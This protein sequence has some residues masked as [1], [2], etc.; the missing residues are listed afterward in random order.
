ML[1]SVRALIIAGLSAL[2]LTP[3]GGGQV[4]SA[5]S[6]PA[7]D[8]QPLSVMTY[9]IKGLP[10][11]LASGREAALERIADRLA[12]LRRERRQPHIVL[13]QEAFVPQA[14]AIAA[15]AGYPYSVAG[16]H[17]ALR[18]PVTPERDDIAYLNGAFWYYGEQVG[19]SL[20]SGLLILSDYPITGS[21]RLAFPD[22][23]CAGFDCLANKG[24]LLAELRVPGIGAV[25]VVDT[26]LN[27]RRAAGV[28]VA[29]SQRAFERQAELLADFVRAQVPAGRP[30]VLGGDMNIG[31]DPERRR[32]FFGHF[33]RVGLGFVA[34]P[35]GGL[36]RALRQ[37]A[38]IDAPTRSDLAQAD[39]H[40]KD[41]LFARGTG[42]APLPVASGRVPFG[43]EPRGEPL[44]DHYGYQIGYAIRRAPT[45]APT[46]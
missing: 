30:L 41:W 15:R 25:S 24:A 20:G 37:Q 18:I 34:P 27:A 9:N 14:A 8:D 33:A 32:A 4:R 42:N 22:F 31:G 5:A 21:A 43:A 12:L 44:S 26:H 39:R 16:P 3:A 13:M 38:R 36:K 6:A 45:R 35:L 40:G 23:A 11:P 2:A 28:P 17:A 7:Y 29:R 19:K 46:A 10:W 1:A